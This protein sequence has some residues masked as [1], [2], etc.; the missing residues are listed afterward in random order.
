MR[1]GTRGGAGLLAHIPSRQELGKPEAAVAFSDWT[2]Y[3]CVSM[4]SIVY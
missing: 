3:T 1:G 4:D 2:F